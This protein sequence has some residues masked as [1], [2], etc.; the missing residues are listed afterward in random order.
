MKYMFEEKQTPTIVKNQSNLPDFIDLKVLPF[1]TAVWIIAIFESNIDL[2]Y[3][4]KFSP[5]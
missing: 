2:D 3:T 5:I 4:P 1:D